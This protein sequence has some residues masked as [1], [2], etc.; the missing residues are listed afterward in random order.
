MQADLVK[1]GIKHEKAG[2]PCPKYAEECAK[3]E[4]IPNL[5][6]F[7]FPFVYPSSDSFMCYPDNVGGIYSAQWYKDEELGR[8]IDKARETLDFDARLKIYRE[9]QEKIASEALALYAYEI[10]AL[11]T[12]QDYPIGPGET[13]PVVGPTVNMYNWRIDLTKKQ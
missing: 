13:F 4:T 2:P 3:A 7:L 12:S 10:P 9:Q 1:L 11:L 5:T 6:I 8:L